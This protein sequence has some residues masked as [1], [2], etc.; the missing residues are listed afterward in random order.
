MKRL[1]GLAAALLLTGC[2]AGA[3]PVAPAS[4]SANPWDVSALPDPCRVVTVA[5]VRGVLGG[6]VG[7]GT[8]MDTWPPMCRFAIDGT[9][10]TYLYVSDNS[11]PSGREDF[12]ARRD[13]TGPV[14]TVTGIGQQAYWLPGAAALHVLSGRTH[15][16]VVFWGAGIPAGAEDKAVA[17]ARLALPRAQK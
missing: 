8:R 9:A 17:L 6:T 3:A 12:E 2:V 16:V 11:L 7:T 15:L 14:D 5:E 4:P 13:G 10:R 1:A